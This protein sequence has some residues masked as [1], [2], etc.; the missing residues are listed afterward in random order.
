M[1]SESDLPK[2]KTCEINHMLSDANDVLLDAE[3]IFPEA[4]DIVR[5]VYKA[6]KEDHLLRKVGRVI[7]GCVVKGFMEFGRP[8]S[9]LAGLHNLNK[10]D[11]P[12]T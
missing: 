7:G 8:Y 2:V 1:Y 3:T 10:K 9:G 11:Q 12:N 6:P 4:K 5:D